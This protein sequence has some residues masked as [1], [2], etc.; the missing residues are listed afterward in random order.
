VLDDFDDL[1]IHIKIDNGPHPTS[2]CLA[3]A[4]QVLTTTQLQQL[5]IVHRK[6]VSGFVN[7]ICSWLFSQ[8]R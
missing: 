8:M 6:A 2:T 4:A 3:F 7:A 5:S 1:V